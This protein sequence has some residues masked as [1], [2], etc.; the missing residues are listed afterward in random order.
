MI[1]VRHACETV[2]Y[3]CCNIEAE[4]KVAG[5]DLEKVL[6]TKGITQPDGSQVYNIYLDK[7]KLFGVEEE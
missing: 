1:S 4:L 2:S 7:S 5:F 6:I 3:S